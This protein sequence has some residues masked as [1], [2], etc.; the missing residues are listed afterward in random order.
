MSKALTLLY[1]TPIKGANR[2]SKNIMSRFN[3][4]IAISGVMAIMMLGSCRSEKIFLE[5][6]TPQ[7]AGIA[8]TKITDETQ[9]SV[10]GNRQNLSTMNLSGSGYGGYRDKSFYWATGR[11][12]A[13][14]PDGTELAYLSITDDAPNVMI[15]KAQAG[16]ASTQRTFR[17]AGTIDWGKDGKLYF[18]DN[19]SSSSTIGSVDAHKGSLVRQLT[20]NNND[21]YPTISE[22]GKLMYFTRF[23]NSGPFIWSLNTETGELTNCTKGFDPIIS[24]NDKNVIYCVRNS[25]KGNSEIWQIDLKNGNETCI[26]S[27]TNKGFSDPALSPDGKWLLVVG[28]SLSSISK[29]QNLDIYAVRTDGTQLTQITYHPEI[30]NS[31]IWSKDG[32]YIYFISSRANKDR[33]FNIWRIN[34]PFKYE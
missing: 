25:I 6:A 9:N 1:I 2:K 31:P 16:G 4:Y 23:D 18:N 3:N 20:S 11:V 15:K 17:R 12:L 10:V 26:L 14:S 19:T 22:D 8:L 28:N 34:N 32:N 29:K 30:D 33:K 13:M 27:D 5:S 21:W 7:E 24:K